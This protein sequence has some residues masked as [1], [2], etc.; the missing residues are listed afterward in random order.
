MI[1]K[2]LRAASDCEGNC[3]A[4]DV[5]LL[6]LA[7]SLFAGTWIVGEDVNVRPREG[8]WGGKVEKKP[9]RENLCSSVPSVLNQDGTQ[10]SIDIHRW[11]SGWLQKRRPMVI[12]TK[13]LW[14]SWDPRC[15]DAVGSHSR[16]QACWRR[17]RRQAARTCMLWMAVAL[18]AWWQVEEAVPMDRWPP[19][20]GSVSE[21]HRALGRP[22]LRPVRL[23]LV[24]LTLPSW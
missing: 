17:K 9:I 5:V 7:T 15:R 8:P 10:M 2:N 6:H 18:P 16:K 22:L 11:A 20:H 3:A 1:D 23:E 19:V 14:V 21:H 24:P 13:H 4:L 12:S